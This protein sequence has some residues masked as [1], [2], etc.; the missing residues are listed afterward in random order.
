MKIVLNSIIKWIQGLA[1][2]TQAKKYSNV[3]WTSLR[4]V[5]AFSVMTDIRLFKL[6]FYTSQEMGALYCI[7]H[8][9]HTLLNFFLS[10]VSLI[11]LKFAIFF[12]SC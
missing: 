2:T 12:K 4:F 3:H 8:K 7:Q 11:C 10:C 6:L 5:H 9:H 1:A